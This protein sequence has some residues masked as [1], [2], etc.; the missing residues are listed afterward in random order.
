MEMVLCAAWLLQRQ[1]GVCDGTR[2][3]Q[4]CKPTWS[5]RTTSSQ[6]P[7]RAQG[8]PTLLRKKCTKFHQSGGPHTC[9]TPYRVANTPPLCKGG[10]IK[11]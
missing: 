4:S 8:S 7:T 9:T 11:T 10:N 3:W 1:F 2:S 5:S 6:L